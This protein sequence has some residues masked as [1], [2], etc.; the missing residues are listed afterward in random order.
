MRA[1]LALAGLA[2]AACA[3]LEEGSGAGRPE[4][5]RRIVSL[6][7]CADQFVL[8]LA[9]RSQIAALSPDAQKDFSYLRDEARGIPQVRAQAEDVIARRPDLVV[10]SYGGGPGAE[11]FFRR[12][13]IPVARLGFAEDYEAIRANIAAMADAMGQ[14][15]RGLAMIAEFDARLAAIRP[16]ADGT[17]GLYMTPA[18]VTTGE[19]SLIHLMMA[20]AGLTN[21][22]EQP[23]WNPLPLERLAR[24]RPD[25]VVAAFFNAKTNHQ[26]QWSAARHPVARAQ[27]AE[28]PVVWLDGAVTACGGWFVLDA[29]EAM[30]Q[31]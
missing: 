3:P 9:D 23:G 30:A 27:L 7:Y 17:T 11:G 14:P 22:Q 13:G 5:P 19:G 4:R 15:E 1:L 31:P 12:A 28:L 25:L 16:R 21:F 10:R 26:D 29:I 2:L 18:G 6:D 24:E 20:S 8:A